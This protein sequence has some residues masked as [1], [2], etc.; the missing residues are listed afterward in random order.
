[1]KAHPLAVVPGV[2]LATAALGAVVS[3]SGFTFL[4]WTRWN[5]R[6]PRYHR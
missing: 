6:E 1:M 3:I 4:A 2:L 5:E